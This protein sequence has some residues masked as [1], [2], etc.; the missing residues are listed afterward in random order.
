MK[1][2]F[3]ILFA[4]TFTLSSCEETDDIYPEID[5]DFADRFP[6]NCDT[7]Y[8]GESFEFK[9]LFSD[10]AELGSYSLEIHHNFD[11]HTHSTE[12]GSCPE[13]PDKEAINDFQYIDEYLIPSGL[14]EYT[15]VQEIFIPAGVDEGDYHFM[16]R[17]VDKEGWQTISGISLKLLEREV[18]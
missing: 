4:V 13:H 10:N 11:H 1:K 7:L 16:I 17:L 15:A 14:T 9:A 2:I 5:R 8:I 12:I 3:Y 18:N 6:V